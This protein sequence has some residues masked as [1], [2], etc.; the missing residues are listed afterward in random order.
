GTTWTTLNSGTS[1][2][3][4]DPQ[5]YNP[6]YNKRPA[7]VHV[8]GPVAPVMGPFDVTIA[9]DMDVENFAASDLQVTGGTVQKFRGSGYFYVARISPSAASTSV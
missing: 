8:T 6:G 2:N 1:P 9:F 5:E 4:P 7:R 3:T